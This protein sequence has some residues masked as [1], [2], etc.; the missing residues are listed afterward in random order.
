MIGIRRESRFHIFWHRWKWI[1]YPAWVLFPVYAPN[2]SMPWPRFQSRPWAAPFYFLFWLFRGLRLRWWPKL[3]RWVTLVD[4]LA[5]HPPGR[6]SCRHCRG[7]GVEYSSR[8][9]AQLARFCPTMLQR[10]QRKAAHLVRTTKR[11]PRWL[12]G[13]EPEKMVR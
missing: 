9:G 4:M 8:N 13:F 1:P 10:F 5:H 12:A 3:G 6:A 7:K 11:G 2:S